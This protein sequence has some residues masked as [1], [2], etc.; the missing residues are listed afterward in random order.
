MKSVKHPIHLGYQGNIV[1][2]LQDILLDFIKSGTLTLSDENHLTG[3]KSEMNEQF[4]G[5]H[6]A[7][8]VR[9]FRSQENITTP[10]D[11][12]VDE[13]TANAINQILET[14]NATGTLV[15]Q[16]HIYNANSNP[17][18]NLS[19]TI[20]DVDLRSRENLGNVSTDEFGYFRLEITG[21][22]FENYEAQ[23][24]D[25]QLD[26]VLPNGQ[27]FQSEIFYNQ[28]DAL[29][30]IVIDEMMS[31]YLTSEYAEMVSQITPLLETG[32]TLADLNENDTDHISN[33][34]KENRIKIGHF[35][36]CQ[37]FHTQT[38]IPADIYYGLLR[39]F[40][41]DQLELLL[42]QPSE[43]L[44]SA[45]QWSVTV[46]IIDYYSDTELDDYVS[47][48]SNALSTLIL[49]TRLNELD[50]SI[51]YHLFSII[52][53]DAQIED[54]VNDFQI[55]NSATD[56]WEN[57]T[58]RV[59]GISA[60]QLTQLQ[61]LF[62]YIGLCGNNPALIH[63]LLINSQ[64]E[65]TSPNNFAALTSSDWISKIEESQNTYMEDFIYPNY[66]VGELEDDKKSFYADSLK[67]NFDAYDPQG[68]IILKIVGDNETP[69]TN[70]NTAIATFLSNN[71]EFDS[72][73]TPAILLKK[74]ENDF[75]FDGIS[76][77]DA[78]IEE[79]ATLQRLYKLTDDYS[80][81]KALANDGITSALALNKMSQVDFYEQYS[82]IL[83]GQEAAALVYEKAGQFVIVSQ[84]L[85]AKALTALGPDSPAVM[86]G[87]MDLHHWNSGGSPQAAINSLP[88][89]MEVLFGELDYCSC[90]HCR[91]VYS[92]S[93]YLADSLQ[94]IKK[95]NASGNPFNLLKSKR[96]DI[97]N[98]KLSC[99]N[100]NNVLPYIDLVNEIL[101]DIAANIHTGTFEVSP[102][103]TTLSIEDLRAF[104]EYFNY[105]VGTG[106]NFKDPYEELAKASIPDIDALLN[107]TSSATVASSYILNT[108]YPW[109]LP[110]DFYKSQMNHYLSHLDLSSSFIS[111]NFNELNTIN[112]FNDI[113]RACNFLNILPKMKDILFDAS[114]SL[115]DTKSYWG[116][117][118]IFSQKNKVHNPDKSTWGTSSEWISI[119]NSWTSFE[120]KF[121]V[122]DVFLQQSQLNYEQVLNLLDC[123][124]I[125]PI[126][127]TSPLTRD[128]YIVA[129]NPNN[130]AT[131]V[132]KELHIP[133]LDKTHLRRIHRFVRLA[134]LLGWDFYSLDKVLMAFEL[135]EINV[136]AIKKIASLVY[137]MKNFKIG[138]ED[139]LSYYTDILTSKYSDYSGDDPKLLDT[140]YAR[141]FRKQ[142]VMESFP[143]QYP[144]P[145]EPSGT[146]M[147][148]TFATT[149]NA[150]SATCA[151]LSIRE[152]E[153]RYL[154]SKNPALAGFTPTTVVDLDDVDFNL[155]NLSAIYR[156]VH[157]SRLLGMRIKDWCIMREWML[158]LVTAIT[159]FPQA[160]SSNILPIQTLEFIEKFKIIKS[161]GI[162]F[163]EIHYLFD[164]SGLSNEALLTKQIG[165][166]EILQN[167]QNKWS[168]INKYF[169][170]N[171]EEGRILQSKLEDWLSSE[172]AN[173]VLEVL[174]KLPDSTGKLEFTSTEDIA[175]LKY[176]IDAINVNG[177]TNY[178][179]TTANRLFLVENPDVVVQNILGKDIVLPTAT[180]NAT[181]FN[182]YTELSS[183]PTTFKTDLVPL[184]YR[185]QE[186]RMK[187]FFSVISH[188]ILKKEIR[189]YL[190]TK[191][192]MDIV[193]IENA[194]N[195]FIEISLLPGSANVYQ[196]LL[197]QSFL[198][199][200]ELNN[201]DTAAKNFSVPTVIWSN[202]ETQNAFIGIARL[203]K[204]DSISAHFKLGN[205][206]LQFI[207]DNLS[208]F[209][210][211]DIFNLLISTST[212]A[213]AVNIDEWL[214]FMDWM[215]T[216]MHFNASSQ[217]PLFDV[218]YYD[219]S[220][221][222]TEKEYWMANM[223]AAFPEMSNN[224]LTIL[225]GPAGTNPSGCFNFNIA[226]D[227][228]STETY[229]KIMDCIE[230]QG[231]LESTMEN[232][233]TVALNFQNTYTSSSAFN[234]SQAEILIKVIK[235]KYTASEWLRII[236]PINDKL[237]IERRNALL[238]SLLAFPPESFLG[239]WNSANDLFSYLYL[240][241]EMEPCMLTSRTRQAISSVQLFVDRLCLNLEQDALG[242]V[243]LSSEGIRQWRLWR[244]FYRVWEANRKVFLYPENWIEPELRDNKSPLF[245]ELEKFLKQNEVTKEN[246]EEAYK[247]Y[248]ERLDEIS[249]LDPIAIF[250]TEYS[251]DTH[252]WARS[253]S[254][255][256]LYYY[257]K[258][259]DGEWTAWEKMDVQMEGDHFVP[260]MWR[261]RLR[262]YWL[263]F[264]PDTK[265]SSKITEVV[266]APS[267]RWKIELAWTELK[268]GKWLPK[269]LSK[270]AVYSSYIA[271]QEHTLDSFRKL[272]SS[273]EEAILSLDVS[274]AGDLDRLKK[275]N[276]YLH[277]NKD[278]NGNLRFV[279]G[280]EYF[281]F[282]VAA[283]GA[284][285][286]THGCDI[287][288]TS[289]KNF[290]EKL[291]LYKTKR[292]KKQ[293]PGHTPYRWTIGVFHEKNNGVF[294]EYLG[295]W[296]AIENS[297]YNY[298]DDI[299]YDAIG[300]KYKYELSP[301]SG[302][303]HDPDV[304]KRQLLKRAPDYDAPIKPV[305][306]KYLVF[307]K[308]VPY[309]FSNQ[310]A[311]IQ[312]EKF[313]Y[314]D[315]RN[316][317]FVE[318]IR[319]ASTSS[320]YE[321][322]I[323]FADLSIGGGISLLDGG[324]ISAADPTNNNTY[325]FHPFY[326]YNV[327]Q[328][329]DVFFKEGLEGLF[330]F[331]NAF[332]I[333]NT[334]S[335]IINFK[336]EYKPTQWVHP[337]YP[338]SVLDFSFEGAYSLYNWELFY[339][340]PM[341][342][343]N[344]LMQDQRF[345]EARE[346]YQFVFDPSGTNTLPPI[347]NPKSERFWNFIPFFNEA[348]VIQNLPY[349]SVI[350]YLQ[351]ESKNQFAVD[352]WAKNP[353]K[354]HVI[355]RYRIS[356]YMKNTA[357]KYLDN[358][359]AWGDML[360]RQDTMESINEATLMYILA[361]QILGGKPQRLPARVSSNPKSYNEL[362]IIGFNAFSNAMVAIETLLLPTGMDDTYLVT[363]INNNV[364]N[365]GNGMFYFC[366]PPNEKLLAYWDI[367][368][369][370]LFKIRHCQNI[371]GVE[372]Q[373]AL[374]APPIDPGMLVKA[375]ANGISI[376]DAYADL[377][378]PL[379]QYR[380]HYIM[381]KATELA[382][383]LK[384]LGSTLLSALEKRDAESI[385]L[386]RSSQELNML[387]AVK[388]LRELQIKE[389]E[390]QINILSEQQKMINFR[391]AYYEGLVSGGLNESETLQLISLQLSIPLKIAQGL[392]QT[393][394]SVFHAL[395]DLNLQTPMSIGPSWG[396]SNL[397]HMTSAA[398]NQIG[399][400]ATVNDIIGSMAATKGSFKRRE[401][402][403]KLQSK[404]AERELKQI[405]R[406]LVAAE[407]RKNISATEL[408]NHELQSQ[409]AQEVDSFMHT[410]FTNEDLYNWMIGEIA[411]T[412]FQSYNLAIDVAKQAQRCYTYELG[413]N[414]A[415]F[416]TF[417]YWKSLKKGLLA[418]ENLL[419]DLKRM[420]VSFMEQHKRQH[421]ITKHIS[422]ATFAPDAIMH[423]KKDKK[424]TIQIPEWLFDMD[425]P[426]HYFRRIKSVS[427]SIP[428]V[429]GPHTSVSCKLSLNSSAYRKQAI[430]LGGSYDAPENYENIFGGGQSIAT[431]HAQND[432]GM[433]EFNFRDER[434]LPFEGAGVI[435]EWT[436]ELPAKYAQFD[437]D[438]ISDVI[439]HLNYTARY[440]KAVAT[441]ASTNLEKVVE[442]QA[443]YTGG[444]LYRIFSLKH[445]FANEWNKFVN[446][447]EANA[448]TAKLGI[449]L[450]HEMFP[451]F[452]IGKQIDFEF[453]VFETEMKQGI[454]LIS[455]LKISGGTIIS[456]TDL[457][458]TFNKITLTAANIGAANNNTLDI[459]FELKVGTTAINL[460]DL[461][462]I[463]D[464]HFALIYKL[465]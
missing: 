114:S 153:L 191:L 305:D 10:E 330:R 321:V 89:D 26:I 239:K 240:D 459:D 409:N 216:R 392:T 97:F 380:F 312:F 419:L 289:T 209:N 351:E 69:F 368:A 280:E 198:E 282:P 182:Y 159:P 246:V 66:V 14:Q 185:S 46:N 285:L 435:S 342:I 17:L 232:C 104:P 447:V 162:E 449:K 121:K 332:A 255:P 39:Q 272:S 129:I 52:L 212:L 386:I 414:K 422:L 462:K 423:L 252:A 452:T 181:I 116:V 190:A 126:T 161:S 436:I 304:H 51:T 344:R 310:A 29:I 370:R 410:K 31:I 16:G 425:Y 174:K 242:I 19:L 281:N 326:H 265:A 237:R 358:L 424:V 365:G 379:P 21:S 453:S 441:E 349:S 152:D 130:P 303:T 309:S 396:G 353:F 338:K 236:Q 123:Y 166:F 387:N 356:A 5:S 263:A 23:L 183:N 412:Y 54:F 297:Y 1:S 407:I 311:K 336:T 72:F 156:E 331:S 258:R 228:F 165:V 79:V 117:N 461:D 439:I 432:S 9:D 75:N 260:V 180:A 7:Q 158:N 302:Y 136:E 107:P 437:Y 138:L 257:R 193:S 382:Q 348:K 352:T 262:L 247:T 339:H 362:E 65:T 427:I 354:P 269:K 273:G 140:Q 110:Y 231:I 248:L 450:T 413:I 134:N 313:F 256:P 293:I 22:Q 150:I 186:E 96:A 290:N 59:S 325:R 434:Y 41:P 50:S 208:E 195:N 238:S 160:P 176:F 448:S 249:H 113:N 397:G 464:I 67:R 135:T 440:D 163:E 33:E 333:Y 250:N 421:E 95:N 43:L 261:G 131:C 445:E 20:F 275:E 88:P 430:I 124:F 62:K 86:V 227:K 125:N 270:E 189:D 300:Y 18:Q 278:A 194:L 133:N 264:T 376:A 34:L 308:Q 213:N 361:A 279:I 168:E 202:T 426:G 443:P 169:E 196:C 417:G 446:D 56:Y 172:Q 91:S 146:N 32:M 369:D 36:K 418:G 268:D 253:R 316:L 78:F 375:A 2:T 149:N 406:Q 192:K 341:L 415:N 295:D 384:S 25:I 61:Y 292:D 230:V 144:F 38:S 307:Q 205:N 217:V 58:N 98:L 118:F 329:S 271:E 393:L 367:V 11:I 420:D 334:S 141:I 178:L 286:G 44:K 6:T 266:G 245:V 234:S 241:F 233:K 111:E 87:N 63:Y 13:A 128:L 177:G 53:S 337:T 360:F 291:Q 444:A 203:L 143:T 398:S 55:N 201:L 48:L 366:I 314:Q 119:G 127:S 12:L 155:S 164:E 401:E 100:A 284:W 68:A 224:D 187:Y 28:S 287:N 340:I 85:A 211:T 73:K 132:P 8:I 301:S 391:K 99:I 458:N 218:M 197:Q 388:E 145:D 429:A 151:C 371:E 122:L 76:D 347:T 385:A 200:E 294:A 346:W 15:I 167:I 106:T 210:F 223:C 90:K 49:A 306:K 74:T 77:K 454:P 243:Y 47:Q 451:H 276:I 318:K 403:W 395:P 455:G 364:S 173:A 82:S 442:A 40:I 92:P 184:K 350:S 60:E 221:S 83:G 463:R 170:S 235:G 3:L 363:N 456:N 283:V 411:L 102:R 30:N 390:E 259:V 57:L 27:I 389:A 93:A 103:D 433:F 320:V 108:V 324:G 296:N 383:E 381:S 322:P 460:A 101:E 244:K 147:T 404:L 438:T 399:I 171:D 175:K 394:S 408:R 204:M 377:L 225:V 109:N 207:K 254:H 323:K 206:E 317:F 288:N 222:L 405:E 81:M 372:R 251:T 229:R 219:S 465:S 402:E 299:E 188:A 215:N 315:Y 298:L 139:A 37:Q 373:L 345:F 179:N 428:C 274:F 71:N 45:L 400:A 112:M 35:I 94:F 24:P 431:S 416:I 148:G 319:N 120:N 355:A 105:T 4:F 115:N 226:T 457:D 142:A 327:N 277:C 154:V 357:M 70:Y 137:L 267:V 359:I 84:A 64:G 214:S 157:L 343:A 42:I 328:L 80:A 378:S 199:D 335:D 374:F 220:Y